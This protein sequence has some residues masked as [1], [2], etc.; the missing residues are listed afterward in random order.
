M[1][2]W[3]LIPNLNEFLINF[4]LKTVLNSVTGAE[5]PFKEIL[6]FRIKFGHNLKPVSYHKLQFPPYKYSLIII[7]L[8]SVIFF[9]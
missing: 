6:G 1:C 4:L 7:N 9:S 3:L 5:L 8:K 2:I